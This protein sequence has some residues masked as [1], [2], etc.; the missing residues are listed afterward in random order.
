MKTTEHRLNIID[1]KNNPVEFSSSSPI[2]P[3]KD[4]LGWQ[5]N[6]PIGYPRRAPAQQHRHLLQILA[7]LGCELLIG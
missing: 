1:K 4:K 6:F 7:V 5:S 3:L 2:D